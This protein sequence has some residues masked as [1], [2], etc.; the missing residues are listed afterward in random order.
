MKNILWKILLYRYIVDLFNK[1][2]RKKK[3]KKKK[4][5]KQT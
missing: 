2:E 5:N 1:F 4:K 3:K